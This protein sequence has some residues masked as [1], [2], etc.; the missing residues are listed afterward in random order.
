VNTE[1]VATR[2]STTALTWQHSKRILGS[3]LTLVSRYTP[4][5][6]MMAY[7]EATAPASVAVKNPEMIPPRMMKIVNRPAR[8]SATRYV[9][10]LKE[11]LGIGTGVMCPFA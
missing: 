8:P 7:R 5:Q 6:R 10:S 2:K 3:S 4:Q 9:F 1:L 11:S